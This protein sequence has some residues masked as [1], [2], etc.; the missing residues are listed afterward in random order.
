MRLT[1]VQ[2]GQIIGF[3]EQGLSQRYIAEVVD[4]VSK[5]YDS[6]YQELG[7]PPNRPRKSRQK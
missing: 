2:K 4:F 6:R 3:I 7:T 1:Y 5:T